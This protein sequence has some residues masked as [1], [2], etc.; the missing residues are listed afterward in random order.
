MNTPFGGSFV[1]LNKRHLSIFNPACLPGALAVSSALAG[2]ASAQPVPLN[3]GIALANTRVATGIATTAAG[4]QPRSLA[5]EV[6]TQRLAERTD[7]TIKKSAS[8]ETPREAA[9]I[10]EG[11][12]QLRPNAANVAEYSATF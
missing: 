11:H 2:V 1:G 3:D 5:G 6:A 12:R 9:R 4:L 8:R 10:R 7:S